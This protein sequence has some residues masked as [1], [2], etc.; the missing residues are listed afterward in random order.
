MILQLWDLLAHDPEGSF[1]N[2]FCPTPLKLS[3]RL[4]IVFLKN[5][6]CAPWRETPAIWQSMLSWRMRK[7]SCAI[8][9]YG[10]HLLHWADGSAS[11]PA[12]GKIGHWFLLMS[13]IIFH[14]Y[15]FPLKYLLI[16]ID[17]LLN[18][19]WFLLIPFG[20]LL[21]T[22]DFRLNSFWCLSISS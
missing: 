13:R 16:P 21:I 11:L 2:W 14:S 17:F 3:I 8:C 4:S 1:N 22:I 18:S 9:K 19:F 6:P 20:F 5:R 15:R 10:M 12:I 7:F